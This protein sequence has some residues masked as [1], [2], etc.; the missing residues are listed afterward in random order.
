MP[1]NFGFRN[2]IKQVAISYNFTMF[3]NQQG[4]LY[5]KGDNHK[6]QLGLGHIS[7][8][9]VVEPQLVSYFQQQKEIIETVSVG[10]AHVVAKSKLGYVYTWGDNCFRQVS[11]QEVRWVHTP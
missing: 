3:L 11:A 9:Y 5:A 1:V 8:Q 2:A 4:L 7:N 10:M 6:G